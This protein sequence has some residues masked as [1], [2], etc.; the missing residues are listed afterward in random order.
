MALNWRDLPEGEAPASSQPVFQ[1]IG[2]AGAQ[3]EGLKDIGAAVGRL[4]EIHEQ[5]RQR[6]LA[7]NEA[8]LSQKFEDIMR[9]QRLDFA[10]ASSAESMAA[11]PE[12]A[13]KQAEGFNIGALRDFNR[14]ALGTEVSD[15]FRKILGEQLSSTA[16]F[17]STQGQDATAQWASKSRSEFMRASARE[18][19]DRGIMVDPDFYA[20]GVA[21]TDPEVAKVQALVEEFEVFPRRPHRVERVDAERMNDAAMVVGEPL[22]RIEPPAL[23]SRNDEAPYPRGARTRDHLLAVVVELRS[24]EVDVGVDQHRSP[25]HCSTGMIPTP[26]SA[27]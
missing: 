12:A 4:G 2:A 7:Q 16:E 21:D 14:E 25:S 9:Q 6:K 3:W 15:G 10:Q 26:L 5:Y 1:N 27:P 20:Q 13:R 18:N 19:A 17:V 22:D 8:Y 24:I 23:D 11:D